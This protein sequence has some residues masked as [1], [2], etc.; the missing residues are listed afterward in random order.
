MQVLYSF[1][2]KVHVSHHGALSNGYASSHD[3]MSHKRA[4]EGVHLRTSCVYY[5]ALVRNLRVQPRCLE[6]RQCNN[7]RR[8]AAPRAVYVFVCRGVH[9]CTYT[10][11]YIHICVCTCMCVCV[12]ICV[13]IHTYIYTSHDGTS[14]KRAYKGAYLRIVCV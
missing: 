3:V 4:Y 13:Y 14:H 1:F 5:R 6:Q 8:H 2:C 10:Y 12:Y 7:T 9:V 11:T